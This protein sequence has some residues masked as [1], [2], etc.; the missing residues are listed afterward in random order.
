MPAK[1][2]QKLSPADEELINGNDTM[3][4]KGE[5]NEVPCY[6]LMKAEPESRIE[7]GVDVKFGI[8]DLMQEPMQTA[9]WDGVR[10]Y[11]AR[12]FMRDQMKIGQQAFFYHSNCKP[13]G[14]AGL[15]TIVK[16][17]YV[18]H[19]QFDKKSAY[20]D[21]KSSKDNPKWFMV[22][23]QFKRK[24]KRYIPLQELKEYYLKHKSTNGPLK[25]IAL[26]T[27]SRLSVQ[28]LTKEEFE[29]ILSIEDQKTT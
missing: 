29:F 8:D 28:P 23:V 6:W 21:P 16:E 5:M 15:M 14:I 17:G 26:F 10:N 13:P 2:K 18:D 19:T 9:H 27:K 25:N 7:N 24:L 3:K 12:N 4:G 1:K 20:C 11:Q 22:D